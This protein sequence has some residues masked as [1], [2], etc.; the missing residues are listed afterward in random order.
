M[1]LNRVKGL[2]TKY[3]EKD[4]DDEPILICEK[5]QLEAQN[6]FLLIE[7]MKEKHRIF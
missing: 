3:K 7:H 1:L 4:K 6:N 5:C 2:E